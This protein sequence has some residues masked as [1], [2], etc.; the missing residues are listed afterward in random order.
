MRRGRKIVEKE[1]NG[2]C[3]RRRSNREGGKSRDEIMVMVKVIV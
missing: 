1:S 2:Y 3:H